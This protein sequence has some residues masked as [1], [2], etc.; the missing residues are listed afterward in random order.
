MAANRIAAAQEKAYCVADYRTPS[1]VESWFRPCIPINAPSTPPIGAA[2]L[3]GLSPAWFGWDLQ[4][5]VSSQDTV[6]DPITAIQMLAVEYDED[7][8]NEKFQCV[9]QGTRTII[10]RASEVTQSAY[11]SLGLGQAPLGG[12]IGK[13]D[14]H[15]GGVPKSCGE[16]AACIRYAPGEQSDFYIGC[17]SDDDIVTVNGQRV[18]PSSG[19]VP[20]SDEDVC[21]VGPRVFAFVHLTEK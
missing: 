8:V 21:T 19:S 10:G 3:I 11:K 17:L 14:C 1:T 2:M 16:Y 7:G 4:E 12:A 9:I 18:I 20:L 6:Y 13:I 15:I 5:F